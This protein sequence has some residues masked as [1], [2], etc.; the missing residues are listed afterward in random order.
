MGKQR[1][2][3]KKIKDLNSE[4]LEFINS[5]VVDSYFEPFT[6]DS[7]IKELNEVI[8]E[9]LKVDID[10]NTCDLEDFFEALELRHCE[11]CGI[12]EEFDN[13]GG[14]ISELNCCAECYNKIAEE[15]EEEDA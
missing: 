8:K 11:N 7:R 6:I 2:S 3:V 1:L 4:Q 9:K 15:I 5:I 12:V 14:T 13:G 10:L